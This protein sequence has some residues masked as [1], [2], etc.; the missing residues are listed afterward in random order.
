MPIRIHK[1]VVYVEVRRQPRGPVL[2]HCSPFKGRGR[3]GGNKRPKR[4][5]RVRR[6]R[7][8]GRGRTEEGREA[9][10]RASVYFITLLEVFVSSTC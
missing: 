8:M 1:C 6:E 7:A 9:E 4:G 10:V 3:G 2:S 5:R